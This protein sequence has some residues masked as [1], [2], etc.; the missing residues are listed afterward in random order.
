MNEPQVSKIIIVNKIYNVLNLKIV[1]DLYNGTDEW[2]SGLH[3]YGSEIVN[4]GHFSFI[5]T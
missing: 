1:I 5:F 2:T 4:F 3:T